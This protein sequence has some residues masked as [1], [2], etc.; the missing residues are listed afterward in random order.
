MSSLV[1]ACAFVGV[2]V[3][4]RAADVTNKRAYTTA[5]SLVPVV[6]GY[7]MLL[8]SDNAKVRYGGAC[9]VAFGVY[10]GTVLIISWLTMS[11]AGYTK[12]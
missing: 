5:A 10:P 8:V 4:C 12:R 6:I 2:I 9:L 7:I 1:F 11:M 3:F